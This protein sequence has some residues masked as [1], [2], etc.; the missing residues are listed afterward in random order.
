MKT[1]WSLAPRLRYTVQTQAQCR[2]IVGKR[3]LDDFAGQRLGFA[4]EQRFGC[5]RGAVP[6]TL[7]LTRWAAALALDEWALPLISRCI[8]SH[9]KQPG[10]L[11]NSPNG[12][13]IQA[14]RN[15]R[16]LSGES[17]SQSREARQRIGQKPSLVAFPSPGAG[18]CLEIHAAFYLA[19]NATAQHLDR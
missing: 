3:K 8:C 14:S 7:G 13:G 19:Y 18:E 1:G 17:L 5:E 9:L 6:R 12:L 11:P 16:S 15:Y 10:R 2:A 4:V